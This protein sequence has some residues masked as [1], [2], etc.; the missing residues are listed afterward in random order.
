MSVPGGQLGWLCHP[1]LS[2]SFIARPSFS[3]PLA[4]DLISPANLSRAAQLEAFGCFRAGREGFAGGQRNTG[5]QNTPRCWKPKREGFS[6]WK[7]RKAQ[8]VFSWIRE[9]DAL[10]KTL[11]TVPVQAQVTSP[12]QGELGADFRV[13]VAKFCDRCFLGLLFMRP[14]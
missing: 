4:K 12:A 13:M 5:L 7:Q 10:S 6:L 2:F 14:I 8:A 3:Q 11:V 9:P 1:L